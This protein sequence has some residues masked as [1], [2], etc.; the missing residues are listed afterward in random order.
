MKDFN[1]KYG[2][3]D[4]DSDSLTVTPLDETKLR[5]VVSSKEH[6]ES[7]HLNRSQVRNL[8]ELL[9]EWS[10]SVPDDGPLWEDQ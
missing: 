4:D 6:V 7:A 9:T 5:F 3:R 8:I 2:C 10:D 1:R